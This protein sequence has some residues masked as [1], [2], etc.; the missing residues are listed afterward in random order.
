[1]V[2]AYDGQD[3]FNGDGYMAKGKVLQMQSD[4]SRAAVVEQFLMAMAAFR[5][6]RAS[7]TLSS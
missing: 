2:D 7:C 6:I 1:V 4:G 5:Y 3:P